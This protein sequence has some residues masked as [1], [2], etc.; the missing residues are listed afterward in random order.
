MNQ[1]VAKGDE[2]LSSLRTVKFIVQFLPI[3]SIY[4]TESWIIIEVRYDKSEVI[5]PSWGTGSSAAWF[6]RFLSLSLW[7]DS[8]TP[9]TN[10]TE[11]FD[12]HHCKESLFGKKYILREDS[13]YCVKCY[14]NLYS[15]TCEEC[16][17]PIGADCKVCQIHVLLQ[18][19]DRVT[20]IHSS[21][22]R[23]YHLEGSSF[24]FLLVGEH[25]FWTLLSAFQPS[26][27]KPF[28]T[29]YANISL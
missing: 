9:D 18:R 5:N 22:T 25:A 7:Q 19:L 28:F 12:C 17:K 11:R 20:C 3:L 13:P 1:W 14:E 27:G 26:F 15:N 6:D 2:L 23:Y 8:W 24:M 29:R 10:M 21:E 4:L 16:K